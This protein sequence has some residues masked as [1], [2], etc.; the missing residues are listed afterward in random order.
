M[1][2]PAGGICSLLPGATETI[3]ALGLLDRLAGV[4]SRC[5][6][7]PEV[8]GLPVLTSGAGG[9][10]EVDVAAVRRIRPR[11]VVAPPELA[12][13]LPREFEVFTVDPQRI[14]EID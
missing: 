6:W 13:Q 3:A 2:A 9:V 1:P 4:S 11:M 12:A 10:P 8:R 5:D 14:V 7:P